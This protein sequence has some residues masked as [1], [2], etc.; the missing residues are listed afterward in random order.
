MPD[1]IDN[2]GNWNYV[3]S[4]YRLSDT[5][6][7]GHSELHLR[8]IEEIANKVVDEKINQVMR[9]LE[10]AIPQAI[11]EYGLQVWDKLINSLDNVLKTD[12]YSK[13]KVGVSGAK[14][15]FYG[16]KCQE[17]ITNSIYTQL[18]DELSKLKGISIK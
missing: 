3:R 18:K 9:T 4:G 17:Y 16:E 1:L 5:H 2:N 12:I 8:E 15:I 7:A 6:G 13:V 11:N 10:T 14:D